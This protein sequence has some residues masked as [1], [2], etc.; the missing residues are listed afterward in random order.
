VQD[1]K[2]ELEEQIAELDKL[3]AIIN[4]TEREMLRVKKRYE[5]V[6]EGRNYA[7]VMLIDRNDEL[8]VLYEKANIQVRTKAIDK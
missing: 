8:C 5:G 4:S 3:S 1:K 7:G 2:V 6:I